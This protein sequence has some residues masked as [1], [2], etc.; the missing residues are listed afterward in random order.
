MA[1]ASDGPA[2]GVTE[3]HLPR[4]IGASMSKWT[5]GPCSQKNNIQS[6]PHGNCS[7]TYFDYRLYVSQNNIQNMDSE[8]YSGDPR[9]L[10]NLCC[11][12]L[13]SSSVFPPRTTTPIS[14]RRQLVTFS[15]R[16]GLCGDPPEERHG[17]DVGPHHLR[18]LGRCGV[19]MGGMLFFFV[20]LYVCW[21]FLV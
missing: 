16:R 17:Q 20:N 3:R 13:S 12:T 21:S 14:F 11:W 19:A 9:F 2:G 7:K 5:P 4:C 15:A 1:R 8:T 18:A 6:N 10:S